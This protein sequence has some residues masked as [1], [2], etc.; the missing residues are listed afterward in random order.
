MNTYDFEERFIRLQNLEL[1][2][3]RRISYLEAQVAALVERVHKSETSI[4]EINA[5]RNMRRRATVKKSL[6]VQNQRHGDT[7]A[8][9][10]GNSQRD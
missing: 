5:R 1:N 6:T 7:G 3:Q 8:Q 2:N 9:T 4:N 10:T